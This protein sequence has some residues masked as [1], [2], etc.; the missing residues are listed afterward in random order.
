MLGIKIDVEAKIPTFGEEVQFSVTESGA[1][2]YFIVEEN[3]IGKKI[4]LFLE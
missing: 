3:L 1:H 2:I 4:N